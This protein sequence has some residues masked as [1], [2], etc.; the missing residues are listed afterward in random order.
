MNMIQGRYKLKRHGTYKADGKFYPTSD[1]FQGELIYS[2]D[3]NLAVLILF[4]V[5]PDK[6]TEFL[7]YT[8]RYEIKDEKTVLHQI[9]N[10]SQPERNNTEEERKFLITGDSLT[11]S[12]K[13]NSE[14]MFEAIWERL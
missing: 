6:N 5:K 1:Y 10:C 8:G 13:L 11:L 7:A 2:P 4:S 9:S 14:N 12:K 3:G